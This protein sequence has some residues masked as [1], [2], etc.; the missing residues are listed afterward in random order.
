MQD[1]V[2]AASVANKMRETRF[3]MFQTHEEEVE[4]ALVRRCERLK[5]GRGR[6]KKNWVRRWL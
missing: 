6:L 2:G 5:R 3:E 4:D 1:K